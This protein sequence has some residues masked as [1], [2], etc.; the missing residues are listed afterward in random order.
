MSVQG[1]GLGTWRDEAGYL[2][3]RV[4]QQEQGRSRSAQGADLMRCLCTLLGGAGE[5]PV[6]AVVI[7]STGDEGG[8]FGAQLRGKREAQVRPSGSVHG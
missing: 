3:A 7:V 8:I 5:E 4:A 1:K 2:K 6:V